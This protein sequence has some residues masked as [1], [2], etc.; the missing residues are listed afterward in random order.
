M[1]A[2]IENGFLTITLPV[3]SQPSKSGKTILIASTH[4][5]V[6][7]GLE[8]DGKPVTISVNAYVSK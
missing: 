1:T 4:G 3:S 5:G 2:K 6:R 8:V 7:N